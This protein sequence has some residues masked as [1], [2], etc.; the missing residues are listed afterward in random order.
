MRKILLAI[1]TYVCLVACTDMGGR[2]LDIKYVNQ[3]GVDVY[4]KGW[5][6]FSIDTLIRSERDFQC[7]ENGKT[8]VDHTCSGCFQAVGGYLDCDTILIRFGC[9][10]EIMYSDNDTVTPTRLDSYEFIPKSSF[11]GVDTYIFTFTPEM[12]D[13]ATPINPQE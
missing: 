10:R 5:I 9:E 3:S 8:Y 13:A 1:F 6:W 4:I 2:Q 12:Y 11:K 7:I